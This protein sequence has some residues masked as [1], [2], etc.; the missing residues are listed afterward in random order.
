MRNLILSA[1]DFDDFDVNL[2][3]R[4]PLC[5]SFYGKLMDFPYNWAWMSFLTA[6]VVFLEKLKKN[7]IFKKLKRLVVYSI[8]SS[9][10]VVF[11]KIFNIFTEL[12]NLKFNLNNSPFPYILYGECNLPITKEGSLINS[13]IIEYS[14][15][16][17]LI[18][19]IYVNG[20]KWFEI[21]EYS[22][23]F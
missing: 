21:F 10:H 12:W 18:P 2:Q 6:T 3:K 5:R 22:I 15:C 19:W 13:K 7:L 16:Y 8:N 17:Y 11:I 23:L 4:H 9:Y 14:T 1:H 20:N